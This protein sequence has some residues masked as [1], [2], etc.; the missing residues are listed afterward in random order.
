MQFNLYISCAVR[1]D[2]EWRATCS[3]AGISPYRLLL[4]ATCGVRHST[5]TTFSVTTCMRVVDI[6]TIRLSEI[7]KNGFRKSKRTSIHVGFSRVS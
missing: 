6:K 7:G 1:I 4:V 3:F 2:K 5:L